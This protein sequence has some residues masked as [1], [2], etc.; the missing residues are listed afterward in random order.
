MRK[1]FILLAALSVGVLAASPHTYHLTVAQNSVVEGQP[2]KAGSYK[3]EMN[4]N[5]AVIRNGRHTVKVPAHVKTVPTKFSNT[6]VE[7]MGKNMQRINFGG[8]HTSI[9]FKGSANAGSSGS[10]GSSSS[11]R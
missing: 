6:E 1:K 3:L 5:T 7:Y 11:L 2:L 8:T 9:I 10:A 4:N